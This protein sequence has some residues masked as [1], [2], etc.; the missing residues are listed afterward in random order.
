[1]LVE[2]GI[3]A[4]ALRVPSPIQQLQSSFLSAKKINL[5]IKR[6]DLI[7]PLLS[8]NKWRKLKYNLFAAEQK[9]LRSLLSF[10]GA[11]SNHIHALAAAGKLLGF[12][13]IGYIRGEAADT[14]SPTLKFAASQGMELHFVSRALYRQKNSPEF[15][16]KLATDWPNAH[17]IPEGGS[18]SLGMSGAEEITHEIVEQINTDQFLVATAVGSGGTAA[19]LLKSGAEVLGV[20]ALKGADFLRQDIEKLL[21]ASANGLDL[22]TQYHFGGYAKTSPDLFEFITNFRRMYGIEL[23]PVYTGKLFYAIFDLI[24]KDYF[25]PQTTIVALHTGGMQ[26]WSGFNA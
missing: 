21:G 5:Y 24:E 4:L 2:E 1:M 18:N 14:L 23:E 15:L 12:N 25:K 3:K 10:G 6:D 22:K 26:G 7:H 8:G 19:G 11:Y 9:G 13:T 17:I 16:A 20:A